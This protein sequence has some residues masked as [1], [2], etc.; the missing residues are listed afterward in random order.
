VVNV[1]LEHK[2]YHRLALLEE[3][4]LVQ[5]ENGDLRQQLREIG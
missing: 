1:I 4:N 3:I 2:Q 5:T